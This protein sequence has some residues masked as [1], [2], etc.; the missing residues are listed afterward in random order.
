MLFIVGFLLGI[1]TVAFIATVVECLQLRNE[2]DRLRRTHKY[3]CETL[4]QTED[5]IARA[6]Q[7]LE[8]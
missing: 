7:E 3:T 6:I 2:V 4:S 8:G 5:R 1:T